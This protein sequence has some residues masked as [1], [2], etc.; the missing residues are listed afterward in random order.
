MYNALTKVFARHR[1]TCKTKQNYIFVISCLIAFNKYSYYRLT[2]E[3]RLCI[4]RLSQIPLP[5][6]IIWMYWRVYHA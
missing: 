6:L 3:E 5:I 4:V 2:S 1:V